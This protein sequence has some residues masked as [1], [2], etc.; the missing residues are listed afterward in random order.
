[1]TVG[2]PLRGQNNLH[3]YSPT[4]TVLLRSL[5]AV[6]VEQARMTSLTWPAWDH[7]GAHN[8][9]TASLLIFLPGYFAG[10]H[11]PASLPF[12]TNASSAKQ[13]SVN[14]CLM[15]DILHT[16]CEM[17][18]SRPHFELIWPT[19]CCLK[20]RGAHVTK[21]GSTVYVLYG[22]PVIMLIKRL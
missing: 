16:D 3:S 2:I 11:Q 17:N 19:F 13:P 10:S 15:Q 8:L 12:L 5:A 21:R 7:E 1:M 14:S 22:G 18:D 20:N 6:K 4:V 9:G